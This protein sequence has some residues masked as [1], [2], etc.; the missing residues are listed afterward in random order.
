MKR[1][2]LITAVTMLVLSLTVYGTMAYLTSGVTA[3]NVITSGN[4]KIELLDKTVSGSETIDFPKEGL[5]VMP[6][7]T[8][9]KEV[10]VKNLANTSWVRVYLDKNILL[11]SGQTA[12][13]KA[14]NEAISLNIDTES[15]FFGSDGFYYYKEPLEKDQTTPPLFT[16]VTFD[17]KMGNEYQSSSLTIQV[18]AQAVQSVNNPIPKGGDVTMVKGWPS[19]DGVP[20]FSQPLGGA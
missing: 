3:H 11:S 10:S 7:T 15:W 8:A 9:S 1:R 13:Q 2:L 16:K 14:V 4:V 17:T 12:E 19:S 6:G 18:V 5:K 20:K